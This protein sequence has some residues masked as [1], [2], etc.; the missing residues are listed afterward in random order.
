MRTNTL[1]RLLE[2]FEGKDYLV[3]G[4]R[5][6]FDLGFVGPPEELRSSNNRSVRSQPDAALAKVEAEVRLGRIAGPFTEPPL[7]NFKVSPLALREKSTPG[8]FRLLHN[9]SFPYDQRSVNLNIPEDNIKLAYASVK[10]AIKVINSLKV[11]YL[12]KA[13]I[14]EAYRLV[15]IH[16]RCYNLLGF[17]L[18]G[19]YY[20]DRCLPMGASSSCFIFEKV[21]DGLKHVLIDKYRVKH[22]IKMLDDFLFLG[23][24]IQECQYGLDSFRHLCN[25][26]G[27][28][29]AEEKTVG[30]TTRII[31]LGICLDTTTNEASIP[32]EKVQA[33]REEVKAVTA[34]RA[35]S[36]REL[37]SLIGKL[38]FVCEVIPAGRCFLRSLHNATMGGRN[39]LRRIS[40]SPEA[41]ADLDLW[42]LFLRKFNGRG[43]ISYG[44]TVFPGDL[45]LYADASKSGYGGTFG[46]H[47]IK[48]LYP[49]SWKEYDIQFLELYPIY[50]LI[51][52][53]GGQVAG[54][55][56]TIYSDN[57]PLVHA[58]N[59]HTSRST[60]VMSLL[61]P[62]I[63]TLMT[64][65]IKFSA[66][67]IP[68][69]L[70]VLCD[71]LSRQQE[72]APLL[73]QLG[74]DP[75][76]TQLP[77][78]LLPSNLPGLQ[79]GLSMLR[80]P[81]PR[82]CDT[83]GHGGASRNSARRNTSRFPSLP[84]PTT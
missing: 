83:T 27:V 80:T 43:L 30:P 65:R 1:S 64:Q 74:M 18:K 28:P 22:V 47:Y 4:F 61:R 45:N 44:R 20:Y 69:K 32:E 33:Y 39:P 25:L 78:H 81:R 60:L 63:F 36:L 29:L 13:D 5:E 9:L 79:T 73:S 15:P 11:C 10:D 3:E 55:R 7:L 46:T 66:L 2:S 8:K 77:E 57:L 21:S 17:Q 23:A 41:L 71:R 68:G 26:V 53:F 50:A 62:L 59:S 49:P 34:K 16:P 51:S 67:H 19:L 37:K 24:S 54:K 12:A 76:P 42:H 6:G 75:E 48:G 31:F 35:T 82:S 14:A 56:V 58:L 70:N 72:V 38:Q 40:L 84:T 52:F